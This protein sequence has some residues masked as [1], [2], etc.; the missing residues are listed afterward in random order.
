MFGSFLALLR[1]V[2]PT[3]AP[4]GSTDTVNANVIFSPI[5]C[6]RRWRRTDQLT[7]FTLKV[8]T[9][10]IVGHRRWRRT[11]QL[12]QGVAYFE[13]K[14]FRRHRRWRRTDQLTLNFVI[15][16]NVEHYVTDV[17]AERIN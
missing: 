16:I 3:L 4:N 12:T 15:L 7:L 6:H 13:A 14:A 2:S 8:K 9:N 17:G 5:F 11:D 1:F 10:N